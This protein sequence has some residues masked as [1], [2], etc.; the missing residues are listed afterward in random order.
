MKNEKKTA[1]LQVIFT[2]VKP[3]MWKLILLMLAGTLGSLVNIWI[4]DRIKVLAGIIQNGLDSGIDFIALRNE[5]IFSCILVV[6]LFLFN[7]L[8]VRGMEG[9]AQLIGK[10][11]RSSLNEKLNKVA[12][13]DYDQV[14]AGDLIVRMSTDVE[15]IATTISKSVGPL[16]TNLILLIGSVVMMLCNHVLLT[17][18]ALAAVVLGT[19]LSGYFTMKIL[20]L[21]TAQRKDLAAM[22]MQIDEALLG[23]SLIKAYNAE[24]EVLETFAHR[25]DEM[26]KSMKKSQ[27]ITNILTPLMALVNNLTYVI[28]CIMG[29]FMLLNGTGNMTIGKIVAFILYSKMLSTPIAFFAGILGQTSL[30]YVSMGKIAE[31]LQMDENEDAGRT[32]PEPLKGRVTFDNVHFSYVPGHEII[33]GF[34]AVVEPGSKV[35]IVGPTGAGKTT[36]VNLLMRFYET[37][38]GSISIDGVKVKDIPRR[39]LH[40]ILGM[41]LQET[42]VFTGTIRENLV[43]AAQGVT[44]EKLQDAIERCSLKYMISTMP[45]GL[46]T[47]LSE[48]T[49][50][51]QGQKQLITIARTMLRS[52]DILILD[53]ATS[54]VDTRTELMIQ[55]A[56]DELSKGRTSFVIAHRLSTIKNA[57]VIFVMKDGDI[58]ETGTH[59]EL[60]GK[61][62]LYAD[63]YYSQFEEG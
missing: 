16:F 27:L 56:L 29:S 49:A 11:I 15:N 57:D 50:V 31:I 22:N 13:K 38:E 63:L 51:S 62:G 40:E 47:V 48:Q 36:L 21:Q 33:H 4:P 35:A 37:N 12:L 45:E 42:F 14:S 5:T 17:V 24:E 30:S 7:F 19:V 34:S 60:L 43:Y 8:F 58:V 32:K 18:C 3:Y 6:L 9:Q 25:N 2:F 46:D 59:H 53:E 44:E 20:P 1:G 41:V 61:G 55:N 28:I 52:P 39:T 54:S 23:H 26:A 10:D